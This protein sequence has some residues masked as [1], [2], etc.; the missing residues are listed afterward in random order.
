MANLKNT[1]SHVF[2][3]SG[4]VIDFL[5]EPNIID[6]CHLWETYTL[7]HEEIIQ[8]LVGKGLFLLLEI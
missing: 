6:C 7:V 2:I 4:E 8:G 1:L 3:R 5:E